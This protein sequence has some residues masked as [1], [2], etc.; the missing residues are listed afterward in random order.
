MIQPENDQEVD[1]IVDDELSS[2][3]AGVPE[4][5]AIGIITINKGGA[6]T[7]CIYKNGAKLPLLA[8]VKL[9]ESD[10]LETIKGKFE[11]GRSRN[12]GQ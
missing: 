10:I 9:L 4:L 3:L 12:R 11:L 8:G 1:Q 6:R 7:F 2:L 5:E